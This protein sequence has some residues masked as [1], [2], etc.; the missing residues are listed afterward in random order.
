MGN[1][2]LR[3]GIL[4]LI[5]FICLKVHDVKRCLSDCVTVLHKIAKTVV[6]GVSD[7]DLFC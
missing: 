2:A 3:Y 7:A 1:I 6:A 5:C 4:L